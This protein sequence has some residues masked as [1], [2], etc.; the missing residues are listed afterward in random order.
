MHIYIHKIYTEQNKIRL[1]GL[2]NLYNISQ[3]KHQIKARKDLG[4]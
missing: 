1:K 4:D 2:I 3:N